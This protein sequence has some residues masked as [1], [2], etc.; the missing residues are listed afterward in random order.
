MKK[1]GMLNILLADD[2]QSD[3]FFF[4]RALKEIAIE[5][6]L[7]TVE[8]GEKL[9]S[10]LKENFNHLPDVIFLDLNMPRKNGGECLSEI[11]RDEKLKHIPI[12]VYSTSLY[13]EIATILYQ[14]G[15]HY[16]LQKSDLKELPAHIQRTLSLLSENPH[17]P[18]KDKFFINVMPY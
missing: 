2:D 16:Y 1:S 6:Q 14:N 15:A 12:V 3:R 9:I 5:T 13:E 10:Y 11:K 4:E 8:D 7:T 17:Q 18:P